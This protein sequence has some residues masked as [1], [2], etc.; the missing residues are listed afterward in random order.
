[1]NEELRKAFLADIE[2]WWPL[3]SG[4]LTKVRKPCVRPTC[5]A[6]ATGVKHPAYIFTYREGGRQ[7]CMY[8]PLDLVGVMRQAIANGRR[9]EG[10][11]RQMGRAL[12]ENYRQ[13]R[14][15][16]PQKGNR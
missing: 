10:R 16:P 8:V 2:R 15:R 7:R 11:L 6:C 14:D 9:L 13:Q 5:R 4:S 3:A 1:M 12:I